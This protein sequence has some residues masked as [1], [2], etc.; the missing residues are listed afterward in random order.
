MR[1]RVV[2]G[3]DVVTHVVVRDPGDGVVSALTR[4]AGDERL[5]AAQITAIAL[6]D[7]KRSEAAIAQATVF[8][9]SALDTY[10]IARRLIG[11]DST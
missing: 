1:S 11:R 6:I 5:E 8:F 9:R 7:L 10:D 2:E 3:A 4:F